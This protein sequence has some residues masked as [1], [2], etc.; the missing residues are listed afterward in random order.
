[1]KP[2]LGTGRAVTNA[3]EKGLVNLTKLARFVC[4]VARASIDWGAI[5]LVGRSAN[6]LLRGGPT[7]TEEPGPDGGDRTDFVGPTGTPLAPE[8]QA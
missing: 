5:Y 3:G 4:G 7:L 1:M 2:F 6:Y 8:T